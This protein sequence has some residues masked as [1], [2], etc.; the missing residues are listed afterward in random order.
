MSKKIAFLLL[1]FAF[2]AGSNLIPLQ[3]KKLE[4]FS[5]GARIYGEAIVQPGKPVEIGPLPLDITNLSISEPTAWT[6]RYEN[7]VF[8]EEAVLL[9]KEIN[10]LKKELSALK[11]E[12]TALTSLIGA[13]RK[14]LEKLSEKITS[15]GVTRW[16]KISKDLALTIKNL[17]EKRAQIRERINQ[18]NKKLSELQQKYNS[19]IKPFREAIKIVIDS[20]SKRLIKVSFTTLQLKWSPFY[21]L[22]ASLEGKQSAF[23]MVAVI[24]MFYPFKMKKADLSLLTSAPFYGQKPKPTPWVIDFLRFLPKRVKALKAM[25]VAAEKAAMMPPVEEK[26]VHQEY[27]VG[28]IPLRLGENRVTLLETK[29][30]QKLKIEIYPRL[31]SKAFILT[32]LENTSQYVFRRAPIS[33]FLDGIFMRKGFL[34]T[35]HPGEKTTL[36]VGTDPSIEVKFRALPRKKEEGW[37]KKAVII[38]NEMEIINHSRRSKEFMVIDTLPISAHEDIKIERKVN[39]K[40]DAFDSKTGIAR[41]KAKLDPGKKLKIKLFFKITYPKGKE[42]NLGL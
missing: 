36:F 13:T 3:I 20:P 15:L 30:P 7:K 2:L 42:I 18:K 12:E 24:E 11:A 23:K 33:F 19:I 25:P 34:K 35:L 6:R 22:D 26:G 31:S 40:P 21:Q 14:G 32:E 4:I 10:R 17:Q 29:L 16:K 27:R 38:E 37:R 1:I 8:P 39:P 5:N 41:W 9:K 28:S